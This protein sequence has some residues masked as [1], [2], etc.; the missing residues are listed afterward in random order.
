M[1]GPDICNVSQGLAGDFWQSIYYLP[2]RYRGGVMELSMAQ[3]IFDEEW[4]V[5]GR[6]TEKTGLDDRQIKLIASEAGLKGFILSE[7]PR[8]PVEKQTRFGLVQLSAD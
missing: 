8:Y 7:Y 1:T 2:L 3:I 5:A 4:M 6:L